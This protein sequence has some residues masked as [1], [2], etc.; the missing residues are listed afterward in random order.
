VIPLSK[1]KPENQLFGRFDT[2]FN[3]K[4]TI[5]NVQMYQLGMKLA[6]LVKK[7]NPEQSRSFSSR[8][9]RVWNFI[10]RTGI[11]DPVNFKVS[12]NNT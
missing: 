3:A 4:Q 1:N 12:L 9:R 2:N 8:A 10:N 11:I 6:N 7:S 5:E